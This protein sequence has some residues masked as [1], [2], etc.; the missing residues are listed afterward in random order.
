MCLNDNVLA[1]NRRRAE[2]SYEIMHL[3]G[4]KLFYT[5]LKGLD[6]SLYIFNRNF[7]DLKNI[8]TFITTD[9]RAAKL[10][11]PEKRRMSEEFGYDVICRIHNYVAAAKSLV[12]HARNLYDK[13]YGG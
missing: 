4:Y 10:H 13:L 1:K 7:I 5:D 8:I 2:L 11:F 3:P 12:E 6:I 9:P